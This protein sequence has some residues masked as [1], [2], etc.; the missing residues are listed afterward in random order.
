ML[1]G[2]STLPIIPEHELQQIKKL[3][4][5]SF[6]TVVLCWYKPSNGSPRV[7]VSNN[8][9]SAPVSERHDSVNLVNS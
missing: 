1:Q 4:S 6:A 2:V 5:G 7:K 8:R 3:G 9:T